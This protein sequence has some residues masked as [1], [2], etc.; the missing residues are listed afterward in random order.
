LD[1]GVYTIQFI[2]EA[3]GCKDTLLLE[4]YLTVI[5][6][7]VDLRPKGNCGPIDPYTIRFDTLNSSGISLSLGGPFV[8]VPNPF[9]TIL[10]AGEYDATF[11]AIDPLGACNDT[12][13]FTIIIPNFPSMGF[14]ILEDTFCLGEANT[15]VIDPDSTNTPDCIY[16]VIFA[17]N[18]Y[19]DTLV[20]TQ[21]SPLVFDLP[22]A[23]SI[24]AGSYD[25]NYTVYYSNADTTCFDTIYYADTIKIGYVSQSTALAAGNLCHPNPIR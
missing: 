10:P 4:N 1:S 23:F 3:D 2:T 22:P 20:S 16:E 5:G 25:L 9:D 8:P 12:D 11:V 21:A 14:S 7:S 18:F 19:S 6:A 17:G 13:E 24:N 15:L